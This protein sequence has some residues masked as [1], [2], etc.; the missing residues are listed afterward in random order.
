MC[1]LHAGSTV[2]RFAGGAVAGTTRG[3]TV[4]KASVTAIVPTHN[5]PELMKRAV[6]S[7]VDQGYDGVVEII[8]VFDACEPV[9]P[10]V[11]LPDNRTM[12]ALVNGRSRGLA[13]G[14]NTGIEAASHDFV[15][16]LDDD[17][18][19]LP[20]KLDEQMAAFDQNPD[21]ILVGTAMVVD[22]GVRTHE[23]LL[24]SASVTHRDLLHDRLAGLHS[25]SF[26]FRK[27]AFSGRL[28]LVDESLPRSY[29]EDYDLLLRTAAIAPIVVVNQPLVSVTWQGQSFF[30]GQWAVY[31]EA[32]QY[33]LT[34]HPEFNS[35]RTA[36]G[37]I[38][39]QIAF[40][41]VA[42]GKRREGARWAQR[43]L[44]HDPRQIKAH[45][46]LAMALRLVSAA[47]VTRVAQRFG[48][49]I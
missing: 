4:S 30:F 2:I 46:A 13:G 5:R 45:L 36:I 1:A 37:R 27:G 12:R 14:R 18:Y 8:V 16:F 40:A 35:S 28:G 41:L 23:R 17:D 9:L 48:K 22:D 38:E 15:A 42:S 24:P 3:D 7:I 10:A 39:A 29:G 31:A 49:G 25:S 19:W 44:G 34:K 47:Q 11:T 32:L 21:S 43:S 33:L 20:T 6:Q 26:V